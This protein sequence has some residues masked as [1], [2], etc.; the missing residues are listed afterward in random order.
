MFFFFPNHITKDLFVL[1]S[2]LNMSCL[3]IKKK[4]QGILKGKE[5]FIKIKQES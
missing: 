2:L 4:L 1:V 3:A 5:Q